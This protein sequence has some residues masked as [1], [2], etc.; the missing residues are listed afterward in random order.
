MS[1]QTWGRALACIGAVVGAGFASGREVMVFFSRYGG[2]SWPLI[3]LS[4]GLM[5]MIC[6][7]VMR[8]ARSCSTLYW[9][10]MYQLDSKRLRWLGEGCL[11][12]LMGVTGGAMISASGNL[13]AL[14]LPLHNAYWIG[15]IVALPLAYW[16]TQK[17]LSPLAVLSGILTCGI[18]AAYVLILA[19]RNAPMAVSI[20]EPM[21]LAG[22][23]KAVLFAVAYSGMN[24]AIA[25]G[26]IC[27]CART[28]TRM[29]CRSSLLFGLL[30]TGLLFLSNYVLLQYDDLQNATF[31]IVR[32][33][34]DLGQAGFWLSV[35]VLYLAVFT[36]LT[37]ILCALRRMAASYGFSPR[38]VPVVTLGTPLLFSLVG[39]EQIVEGFYAPVG[40]ACLLLIFVP[41]LLK[42]PKKK[43]KQP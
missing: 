33:L 27:D 39:F 30:L 6:V 8:K 14:A 28:N 19:K 13:V 2:F 21:T 18:L 36:S 35:T 20:Q 23:L 24:M 22:G 3:V 9:C 37:A 26:V 10:G 42:F 15:I 17:N 5:C 12:L 40:L 4:T 34:S 16:L 31:P 25:L 11:F 32:L 38:L 43:I 29:I 7:L 41:T 1:N